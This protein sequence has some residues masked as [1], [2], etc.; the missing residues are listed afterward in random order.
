MD[1]VQLLRKDF[2][3]LGLKLSASGMKKCWKS[4][5]YMLKCNSFMKKIRGFCYT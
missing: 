4:F 5:R 2:R 1:S 3:P